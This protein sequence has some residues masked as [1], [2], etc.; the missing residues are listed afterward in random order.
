MTNLTAAQIIALNTFLSYWPENLTFRQIQDN[1][2]DDCDEGIEPQEYFEDWD[3]GALCEAIEDL[4]K[5]IQAALSGNSRQYDLI[6]Q[7]K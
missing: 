6:D 4:A 1:L 7:K 5:R 3:S 2:Y